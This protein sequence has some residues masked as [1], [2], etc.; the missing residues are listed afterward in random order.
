MRRSK[1]TKSVTALAALAAGAGSVTAGAAAAAAAP[2]GAELKLA[3][4]D[5]AYVSSVR[6]NAGF[7]AEDKLAVG[8]LNGDTKTAFLRF[9][10]PAGVTVG[11]ARLRLTAVGP[12]TG[13]LTLSRVAG[14]AWSERTLTSAN[15]PALGAVVGAATP[16]PGATEVTFDL[17]KAVT[18]PG[19]YAFALQS[20]STS[21]VTRLRSAENTGGP[22]L[23]VSTAAVAATPAKPAP[24]TPTKPVPATPAQPAPTTPAQ[25]A[26]T[27]PAQPVETTPAQP[28]ETTPAPTTP[29]ATPIEDEDMPPPAAPAAGDCVT[30]ELLVPSCGVL[31]GAAA[32]GFTDAPRDTA[33]KDWEKLSGRT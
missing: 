23:I 12:V 2:A 3:A 22:A 11:A 1:L 18:R 14:T 27:T 17:S 7:G 4:T 33:L 10:V 21:V 29:V 30:G 8:R 31:W 19:A 16:A 13:R 25:P 6:K 24:V 5:D 32:G 20:S 26:E 15:A 9:E 28:A